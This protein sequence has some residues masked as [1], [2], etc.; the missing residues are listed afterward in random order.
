M[1]DKPITL[2]YECFA[3]TIEGKYKTL[4][5]N[6][7]HGI[8]TVRK[9]NSENEYDQYHEFSFPYKTVDDK[10]AWFYR[11]ERFCKKHNID[12]RELLTSKTKEN[13]Q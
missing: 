1:T 3:I 7:K 8:F 13:N 10:N 12:Y 11:I 5:I 9:I 6:P 4:T 2:T